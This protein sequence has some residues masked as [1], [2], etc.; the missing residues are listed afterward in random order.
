MKLTAANT[1]TGNTTVSGG[2]LLLTNSGSLASP[3]LT[4]NADGTFQTGAN[5]SATNITLNGGSL[6]I[7]ETAASAVITAASLSMTDGSVF[8]DMNSYASS[9]SNFDQLI[10]GSATL[11]SGV[12]NLTFN[13]GDEAAWWNATPDTGYI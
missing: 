6:I 1:Y 7:G 8:F 13:N 5:I 10:T 12:I 9:S 4:V 3:N 2:T 11:T